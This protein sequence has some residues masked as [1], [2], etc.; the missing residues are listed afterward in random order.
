MAT[1]MFLVFFA[2]IGLVV[3]FAINRVV[4][5][6]KAAGRAAGRAVTRKLQPVTAPTNAFFEAA[7][8]SPFDPLACLRVGDVDGARRALQKLAYEVFR[9]KK[10]HPERV[11]QF[12]RLMCLFV[13]IDPLFWRGLEVI[14]P[15]VVASPGIKQTAL[16][17]HMPMSTEEARYVLYF[18]AETGHLN[19]LKKGNTY[20]V[21]LPHQVL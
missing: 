14:K 17:P 4:D 8:H 5:A 2:L 21:Y 20:L 16:Y 19:R 9:E 12:T 1:F 13:Q 7:R 3:V 11:Q 10:T 15:I 18:A 6:G